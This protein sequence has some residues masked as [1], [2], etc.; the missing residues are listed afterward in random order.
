MHAQKLYTQS[1]D[2]NTATITETIPVEYIAIRHNIDHNKITPTPNVRLPLYTI[3][4]PAMKKD[5]TNAI[6]IFAIISQ[7]C[8]NDL[9]IIKYLK[10]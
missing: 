10:F 4:K 7:P 2:A 9:E 8:S 1:T 5:S 6:I 3:P